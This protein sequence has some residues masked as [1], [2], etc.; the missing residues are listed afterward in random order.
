[1]HGQIVSAT[2]DSSAIRVNW[3]PANLAD[4]SLMLKETSLQ[5]CSADLKIPLLFDA[6]AIT[7]ESVSVQPEDERN[8]V[9]RFQIKNR[10]DLPN[11]FTV[12][13]RTFLPGTGDWTIAGTVSQNDTQFTDPMLD[14]DDQ[15]Y[16][17]K[18]EGK[19]QCNISLTSDF[20]HSILLHVTGNEEKELTEMSWNNYMGWQNGIQAYEI[21]RKLDDEPDFTLYATLTSSQLSYAS[22]NAK[23]GFTH[24]YRIRAIPNV[25]TPNHDDKN[26]F[27]I[28]KNLEL[29]PDHHI[30]IYNRQG[31]EVYQTNSYRQNWNG[32][33][34]STG[35]YY[36][37]IR[38]RNKNQ[39]FKGWL[40]VLR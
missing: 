20:H 38:T 39:S 6:S 18:L 31:K 7:I 21:W 24:C 32:A 22:N 34:L 10:P 13:R 40:H 16:E 3:N 23:E 12:S 29:Y 8:I 9:V 37:L 15:S 17:Y 19:N 25:I 33:G 5:N 26:D 2:T 11:I 30:S 35:I 36:Y 27:W 14:T 1:M 4:I 28:I